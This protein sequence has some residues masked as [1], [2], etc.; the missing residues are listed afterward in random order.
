M[1]FITQCFGVGFRGS[2]RA[3][4]SVPPPGSP[5]RPD[6]APGPHD[7]GDFDRCKEKV[8]IKSILVI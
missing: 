5:D 8:Y 6:M 7:E 1:W 4:D 2:H 3:G